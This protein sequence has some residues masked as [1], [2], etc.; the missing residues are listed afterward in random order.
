MS[1][2][3]TLINIIP[4]Q[5]LYQCIEECPILLFCSLTLFVAS[6]F[7]AHTSDLDQTTDGTGFSTP[8]ERVVQLF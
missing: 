1:E 6:Y 8:I 5:Q 4:Q 7:F 2:E 3:V